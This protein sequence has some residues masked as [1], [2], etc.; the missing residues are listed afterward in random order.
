MMAAIE[1]LVILMPAC[2]DDDLVDVDDCVD[3]GGEVDATTSE[4][5][6]W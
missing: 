2:V 5:R 3:T 4:V 6:T 1:K